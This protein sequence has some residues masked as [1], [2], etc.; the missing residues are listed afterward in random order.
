MYV[1]RYSNSFTLYVLL[2]ESPDLCEYA[3]SGISPTGAEC[4]LEIPAVSLLL[5]I[6]VR[7]THIR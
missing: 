7:K 6:S 1:D 5:C 2:A 4:L 3:L